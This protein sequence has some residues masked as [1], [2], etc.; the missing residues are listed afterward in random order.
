[1]ANCGSEYI[2][3]IQTHNSNVFWN[4]VFNAWYKLRLKEE[5]YKN[6]NC[7]LLKAPLWYNKNI[8]VGKKTVF[9][10]N[11]FNN[12]ITIINDLIKD[13]KTCSF[14]SF[15]EFCEL[16][17]NVTNYLQ[18]HGILRSIKNYLKNHHIPNS[19][20][21]YP[22]IP[23]DL[24]I[25]LKRKKGSQDFYKVL[26][27]SIQKNT[28]ISAQSKWGTIF[29][30]NNDTWKK[31]YSLPFKVTLNTKFQWFQFRINHHILST[32]S[33][34]YK[35]GLTNNPHCTFCIIERET[36]IHI[37]W[38]CNE[39]Q[40]FLT[41]FEDLLEVLFIPFAVNK[42]AMIFGLFEPT[43]LY[44]RID[45]EILLLIKH[46]I[47]RTRCLHCSLNV[48]VLVNL[49]QDYYKV[50]RHIAYSKGEYFHAKFVNEWKK[51]IK[52]VEL[53]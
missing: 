12:G 5:P 8:V 3:Q 10:R 34:I 41:S 21:P 24:E 30:F 40:N 7:S 51:W 43:G 49:I 33:F 19:V 38:E 18:F 37:L 35:I 47:Y 4:D 23:T 42:Q 28:S 13:K 6:N 17:G 20:L 11:W 22:I 29:D 31:I 15:G 36:I 32:N 46:Y 26:I 27:T 1:M 44:N 16:H 53:D 25:I 50:Q 52:L 2:K 39:V 14:Y 9:F 45:N 48:M